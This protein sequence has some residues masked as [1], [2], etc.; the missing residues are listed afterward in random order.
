MTKKKG[1]KID[2]KQLKLKKTKGPK[3]NFTPF[4]ILIA[5][6]ISLAAMTPYLDTGILKVNEDIALSELESNYSESLYSEILIDGNK[7]IATLSGGIVNENGTDKQKIHTAILPDRDSL[8]D[9]GLKNSDINT[10]VEVKDL[11][12]EKFW[13]NMIPTLLMIVLFV[14]IAIF[15]I[16]RM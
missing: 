15:L 14:V 5:I 4:F 1:P 9:L 7:A 13:Q 11:T 6:A 12:S 16:S 10:K 8:A 2:L 3:N